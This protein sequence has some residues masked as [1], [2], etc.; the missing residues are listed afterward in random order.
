MP[1]VEPACLRLG[2]VPVPGRHG[3]RPEALATEDGRVVEIDELDGIGQL[4]PGKG[5]R[6]P[7]AAQQRGQESL[8]AEA[9]KLL[10]DAREGAIGEIEAAVDVRIVVTALALE[11]PWKPERAVRVPLTRAL[12]PREAAVENH[13]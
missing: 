1:S 5:E 4:Q 2:G 9:S 11:H 7:A 10:D 6:Q 12:I 3:G 8:S 13:A